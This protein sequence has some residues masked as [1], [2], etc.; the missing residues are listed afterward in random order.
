MSKD[1]RSRSEFRKELE[2]RF[3][4]DEFANVVNDAISK[5][6]NRFFGSTEFKDMMV[7]T[8]KS[9]VSEVS[10][11]LKVFVMKEI[12]KAINPLND[13]VAVLESCL[14]EAKLHANNNEQYSRRCNLR[15]HGIPEKAGENCYDLVIA[16]CKEELKCDV[17]LTGK[18]CEA[19][20]F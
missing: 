8:T 9:I 16:F 4:S 15:I 11:T 5:E 18:L 14:A 7:S 3:N 2:S 17:A 20:P 10:S 1:T 6:I 13:R 19:F 12:E